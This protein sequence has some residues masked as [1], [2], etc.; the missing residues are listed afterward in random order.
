MSVLDSL[1]TYQRTPAGATNLA[2]EASPDSRMADMRVGRGW[3]Q[4]EWLQWGREVT[5][6]ALL[7]GL[8]AEFRYYGS[9]PLVWGG[10][11]NLRTAGQ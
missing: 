1:R 7:S 6:A 3:Q 11:Y 5:H 10:A 4:V 9:L 8:S 2:P